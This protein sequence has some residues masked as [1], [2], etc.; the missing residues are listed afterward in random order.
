MKKIETDKA[1]KAIGPYSQ[2][3]AAGN[4][5]FTSGQI[6][7]DPSCTLREQT[8]QVIDSL[9]AILAEAG[10]K[11]TDVVRVDVFLKNLKDDFVPMNEEYAKRF[12][13]A[14]APVRQ[15]I[16]VSQLPKGAIIE[17]SCIA[18]KP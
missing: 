17:M 1:P 15:T 4:F 14:V 5:V 8:H 11:L 3:I 12:N 7:S 9:E 2:G 10:C 16:E 6:P 13:G 18:I